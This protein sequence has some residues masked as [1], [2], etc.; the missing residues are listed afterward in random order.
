MIRSNL[1]TNEIITNGYVT[2]H[3]LNKH[4]NVEKH[5]N[6]NSEYIFKKACSAHK[7]GRFAE[8]KKG[9]EKVLKQRPDWGQV[10]NALGSLFIDQSRP[11]KA[12][13]VFQKAVDLNPPH[14]PACYSLGRLK[15]MENDHR[16][17]IKI[18]RTMLNR[19]PDIGE[20][21]NNLG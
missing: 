21:W 7:K 14:L 10:L 16:G 11:D 19:Q 5:T 2:L 13:R 6:D 15:Q 17:A 8:A 12:K 9:Y 1:K 18:Y 3:H 20:A 4:S